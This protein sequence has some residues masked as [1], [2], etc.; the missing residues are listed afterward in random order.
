MWGV[1]ISLDSLDATTYGRV[2]RGRLRDVLE[3]IEGALEAGFHGGVKLNVVLMKGVNEGELWKIVEY[4]AQKGIAAVRFIE[5]MPVS[6]GDV[7]DSSRFLSISSAME[8]LRG[9]DELTPLPDTRLGAG[10]AK[11]WRLEMTGM[12]VGFIGAM[13]DEHFCEQCN[14]VRLT[15]DGFIRPCLGQHG[16]HDLKPALR[17]LVPFVAKR[18]EREVWR[19]PNFTETVRSERSEAS[20][21]RWQKEPVPLSHSCDAAVAQVLR[22]SLAEKPLEHLFRENYT[23]LRIMTAIGG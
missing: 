19:L 16:E 12:R 23:P 9:H 4:A 21:Q 20:A 1:N 11:Y 15:A 8:I 10:P 6:D 22:R 7:T 14:K 3:G 18:P 5:L 17:G 13:T 2:T